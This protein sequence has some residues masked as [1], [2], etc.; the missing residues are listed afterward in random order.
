MPS[1]GVAP[2]PHFHKD[3]VPQAQLL[4]AQHRV[5]DHCS[6][7]CGFAPGLGSLER[8]D[9]ASKPCRSRLCKAARPTRAVTAET[10]AL[11][12]AIPKL[13]LEPAVECGNEN[14]RLTTQLP[15]CSHTCDDR[16]AQSNK[17]NFRNWE[18]LVT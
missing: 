15:G 8:P 12:A 18:V 7:A 10:I 11:S 5:L 14:P 3:G 9:A 2:S 17:H 1:P 4:G 13:W 6:G 16:K